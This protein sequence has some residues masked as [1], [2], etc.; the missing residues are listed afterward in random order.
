MSTLKD[1]RVVAA[2]IVMYVTG[3]LALVASL[4]PTVTEWVSLPQHIVTVLLV[5]AGLAAGF[6][7]LIPDIVSELDVDH[8]GDG[9]PLRDDRGEQM[10]F[11]WT[12]VQRVVAGEDGDGD[13]VPPFADADEAEE[14]VSGLF[15]GGVT[16][17]EP[18]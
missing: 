11:L 6:A 10:R 7:R 4:L 9:V 12:A 14:F 16:S 18:E 3:A 17:E 2:D 8:D 15:T 5:I 13:G 1:P